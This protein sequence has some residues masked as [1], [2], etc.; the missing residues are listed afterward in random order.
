[1]K[2]LTANALAG[3][4]RDNHPSSISSIATLDGTAYKVNTSPLPS[5]G[6]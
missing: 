1:M 2:L 6:A 4:L 3:W 5:N